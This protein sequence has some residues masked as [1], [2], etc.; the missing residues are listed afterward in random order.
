MFVAV[1]FPSIV[2]AT[3]SDILKLVQQNYNCVYKKVVK[4]GVAYNEHRMVQGPLC[5]NSKTIIC[6]T[7]VTCSLKPGSKVNAV[8]TVE[9]EVTCKSGE[10]SLSCPQDVMQCIS[11]PDAETVQKSIRMTQFEPVGKP[12]GSAK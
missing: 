10:G 7:E 11:D 12:K 2:F 6:L 3:S 4:D 5:G 8:A 1:G 9:L